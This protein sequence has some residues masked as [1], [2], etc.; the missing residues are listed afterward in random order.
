MFLNFF[1][2]RWFLGA[3][4]LG[5]GVWVLSLLLRHLDFNVQWH[6]SLHDN[7][8]PTPPRGHIYSKGEAWVWERTKY[9]E[10]QIEASH[11]SSRYENF[12]QLS[13]EE[14]E[15]YKALNAIAAD[16]S[17][18]LAL[19]LPVRTYPADVVKLAGEWRD[20]LYEK[21]WGPTLSIGVFVTYDRTETQKEDEPSIEQYWAGEER[22]SEDDRRIDQLVAEKRREWITPKRSARIDDEVREQVLTELEGTLGRR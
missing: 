20:A 10:P 1:R 2:N 19:G 14:Y 21:T 4:A 17:E 15:R 11:G 3:L 9:N 16:V 5:I 8:V 7:S 12:H 6:S 13:D 22:E 18:E